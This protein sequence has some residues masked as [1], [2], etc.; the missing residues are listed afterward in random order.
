MTLRCEM[1][2]WGERSRDSGAQALKISRRGAWLESVHEGVE[3]LVGLFLAFVGE[4]EGEHGRCEL[5]MAPGR[6]G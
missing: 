5:S 3:T 1:G 2:R 6:A 4:V